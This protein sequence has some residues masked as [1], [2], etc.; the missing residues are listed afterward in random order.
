MDEKVIEK[1]VEKGVTIAVTVVISVI[2]TFVISVIFF[3]FVWSWVVPDLFPG[4]VDDGLIAKDISW[5][6]TIKL[7]IFISLITGFYPSIQDAIK[8]GKKEAVK[9]L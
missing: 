3:K 7:A 8:S 4:A 1:K 2:V 5:W 9:N 6:A